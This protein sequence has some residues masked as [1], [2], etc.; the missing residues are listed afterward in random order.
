MQQRNFANPNFPTKHLLKDVD[1]FLSQAEENGLNTAGL[2]GIR[3]IIQQTIELG[4]AD[5]DY[6]ALFSG[7]NQQL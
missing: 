2:T 1:L 7:I 3:A 5:Q 6:S 4:L